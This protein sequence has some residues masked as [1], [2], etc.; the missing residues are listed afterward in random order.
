MKGGLACFVAAAARF[1]AARHGAFDG[2]IAL[3][4]TGDEEGTAVNGT[5]KVLRWLA[6]RGERPDVCLVGEPTNPG[7]LGETIKI[8][9]RGSLSGVLTVT[10]TAGHAAYPQLADN[11]LPRLI[12][13]L[14]ALLA[15]LD[16]GTPHFE[17]SNLQVTSIDVGNPA[18]NVIPAAGRAMFNARFNDRHT[19]A[20]LE[21]ELR[22]RLDA[23]G[24]AYTLDVHVS[25]EAFLTPPGPWPQLVAGAAR[26]VTGLTPE[27]STSGGTSDARFFKDLCPVA[28]FGLINQ[29]IHKANECVAIADLHALTAVYEQILNEYF[30]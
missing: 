14:A 30:G 10:G 13:M 6:D 2:S 18:T 27:L 7:R 23:E 25:G 16:E 8:G 3:L 11:P 20:T 26:R 28:E 22:R 15:P 21:R 9:R 17:P 1:L 4:V 12:R 5:R 24:G 29:T 19:G